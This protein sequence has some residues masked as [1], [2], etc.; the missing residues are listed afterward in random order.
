M[1]ALEAALAGVAAHPGIGSP[2][3]AT[4]LDLPGLRAYLLDGFPHLVFYVEQTEVVD[5]WRVLHAHRD[6]PAWPAA[7]DGSRADGS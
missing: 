6:M 1:G 5:V 2:R 4:E 3:Y 7:P